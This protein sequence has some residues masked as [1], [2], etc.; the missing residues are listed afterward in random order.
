MVLAILFRCDGDDDGDGDGDHCFVDD[1]D[2]DDSDDDDDDTDDDDGDDDGDND[3]D[4]DGVDA[5]FVSR[6]RHGASVAVT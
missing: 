5:V 4:H 6:W 2:C 3:G 1:G